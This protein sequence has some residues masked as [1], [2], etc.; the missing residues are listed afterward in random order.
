MEEEGRGGGESRGGELRGCRGVET[1]DRNQGKCSKCRTQTKRVNRGIRLIDKFLIWRL[2]IPTMSN[3][4]N[5]F[6]LLAPH[7][8]FAC[9]YGVF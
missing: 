9:S 1:I 4:T 7:A 2:D 3:A 8:V 6:G 5:R